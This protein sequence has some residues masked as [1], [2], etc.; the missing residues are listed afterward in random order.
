VAD[1]MSGKG[2][3]HAHREKKRPWGNG[4]GRFLYPPRATRT[5]R[6]PVPRRADQL[7]TW[8]NLRDA[9]RI[10]ITSGCS[11][12]EVERVTATEGAK[13]GSAKEAAQLL[14]VPVE[15]SQDVDHFTTDPRFATQHRDRIFAT[16][17]ER[18]TEDPLKG[19]AARFTPSFLA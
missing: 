9:C 4:D 11:N 5:S 16:M 10:R 2:L 6:K 3:R 17:I 8:E 14:H 12:S 7:V 13:T 1:P 18:C 19:Y 15:V